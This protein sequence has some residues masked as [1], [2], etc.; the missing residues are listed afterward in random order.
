MEELVADSALHMRLRWVRSMAEAAEALAAGILDSVQLD[1][2]LPDAQGLEAVSRVRAHV[3]QGAI[4]VL[5]GLAEE[6]TGLAAVAGGAQD[7][8]VKGH[9]EPGLLGRAVRYAI[10]R[11]QAQR[12]AVALQ[13]G[14]MQ[15]RE[16]ARL[17][18]GLLPRPLLQGGDVDVVAP[19]F[20]GERRRSSAATPTTSCRVPTARCTRWSATSLGTGPTRRPWTSRR[21]SPGAHWCCRR[22]RSR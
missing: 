9:V 15:A 16:N 21:A 2:R 20:P 5:T 13:S 10:Q 8:L 19:I 7:H 22:G 14:R 18:R 4:V 17:E 11:K 12:S 1:L 3:D 6:L